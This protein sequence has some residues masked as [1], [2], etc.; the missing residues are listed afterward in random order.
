MNVN[1]KKDSDRKRVSR[2][3]IV[4]L[5]G[6][7]VGFVSGLYSDKFISITFNITNIIDM[8]AFTIRLIYIILFL[9][10]LFLFRDAKRLYQDYQKDD[11][12]EELYITINK[13]SAF[14]LIFNS[15]TSILCFFC[16]ILTANHLADFKFVTILLFLFD[17]VIT[18]IVIFLQGRLMKFYSDVRQID[19]PLFPTVKEV[20]NN[21]LQ[22]DEAELLNEYKSSFLI[23]MSLSG[24]V[25]PAIEILLFIY[26]VLT[27]FIPFLGLIIVTIIHLFIILMQF[28]SVRDYYK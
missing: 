2:L 27:R 17:L 21:I 6:G 10:A 19:I 25:L 9:I 15:L 7:I 26:S 24:Y 18:F 11:S 8:L 12:S 5:L 1:K 23:V 16:I 22:Q 28:K 3:L 14:S 13:K 4:L 20:T